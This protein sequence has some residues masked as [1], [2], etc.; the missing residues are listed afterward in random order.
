MIAKPDM[1]SQKLKCH[2][3]R[4]ITQANAGKRAHLRSTGIGACACAR[5]GFFY[6]QSVVDFQKGERFAMKLKFTFG[7]LTLTQADEYGLLHL[8]SNSAA[9]TP[10]KQAPPHL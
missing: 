2:S 9:P 8:W 5:H 10:D 6:P 1:Y 4:A 3:H 7:Y